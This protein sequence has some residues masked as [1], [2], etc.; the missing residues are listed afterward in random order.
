MSKNSAIGSGKFSTGTLNKLRRLCQVEG[1]TRVVKS[2]G[3]CQRHG[4]K[5]IL[6]KVPGCTKQAQGG[7]GRMCSKCFNE[8][9]F[10]FVCV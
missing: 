5:T 4:A 1:C 6:C 10:L 2:Q 7:F 8:I 3:L 9:A